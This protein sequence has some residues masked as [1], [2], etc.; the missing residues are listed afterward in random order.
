MTR[1]LLLLI[2]VCMLSCLSVKA[3][4][5]KPTFKFFPEK[6]LLKRGTTIDATLQITSDKPITLNKIYWSQNGIFKVSQI[7]P[8]PNNEKYPVSFSGSKTFT[9]NIESPFYTGVNGPETGEKTF[10]CNIDYKLNDG[11]FTDPVSYKL[12]YKTSALIYYISAFIGLLLGFVVK[13]LIAWNVE[14]VKTQNPNF[15]KYLFVNNW[16][17]LAIMIILGGVALIYYDMQTVDV[18]IGYQKSLLFGF[19]IGTMGDETLIQKLQGR[20]KIE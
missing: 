20:I 1:K 7:A 3:E 19:A 9:F 4:D 13:T 17:N 6:P 15:V 5:L 2:V 18:A 8:D 14:S 10:L 16:V 11:N 12:T